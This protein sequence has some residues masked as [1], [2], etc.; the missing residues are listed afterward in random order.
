MRKAG[1]VNFIIVLFTFGS[2]SAASAQN[3][4][5]HA[6]YINSFIKYIQWPSS[7]GDFVIGV[8]GDSPIIE[9]L[10]KMAAVKKAGEKSIVIKKFSSVATIS[11]SDIL[12][13]P[14]ESTIQLSEIITKSESWN[15][16]IIT[17]KEG[18]GIEG[19]GI[20]FVERNGKLSFELNKSS[21]EAARLKVSTELT[22][23]A[24]LI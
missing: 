15:T 20:N 16:L 3:Y 12:F 8:I 1:F 13:L 21:L 10:E 7:E 19:S 2:I 18:L 4:Q 6:V 9:H 22:R 11:N 23:L 14:K 24:I 17:E 5:L